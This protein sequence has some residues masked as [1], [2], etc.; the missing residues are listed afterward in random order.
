MFCHVAINVSTG[1]LPIGKQCCTGYTERMLKRNDDDRRNDNGEAAA[2]FYHRRRLW[3]DYASTHDRLPDRGFRVGFWLAKRMNGD[4][5]CC[6]YSVGR[7]AKEMGKSERYVRYGLA[8][9]K[10]ANLMLV[11][12]S[13]G[14]TNS[15]HLHAPFF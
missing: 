13:N 6:W 7:I 11:V 12:A 3:L 1:K 2:E 14:K 9:L 5:Q 8:D 10:A 15:Y 4:D